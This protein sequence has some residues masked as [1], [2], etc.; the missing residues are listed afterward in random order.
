MPKFPITIY[1]CCILLILT[2]M[3]FTY[4][5]HEHRALLRFK[6]EVQQVA[7][8][9]LAENRAHAREDEIK[10]KGLKNEL[11]TKTLLLKRYY[12]SI[13]M[14][15]DPS[16]STVLSG[17]GPSTGTPTRPTYEVLSGQ[18]AETTLK[19]MLLQQY[20]RDRLNAVK[21]QGE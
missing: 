4:G 15:S 14:H 8:K 21:N 20:E 12:S 11:D 5:R 16:G 2:I 13:G 3:G 10:F 19:Y 17:Q 6:Q 9:Q 18:C 7:D 1:A